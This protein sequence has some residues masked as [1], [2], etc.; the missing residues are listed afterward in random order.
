MTTYFG[1]QGFVQLLFLMLYLSGLW[2]SLLRS[3]YIK[4]NK[5]LKFQFLLGSPKKLLGN[6]VS[7]YQAREKGFWANSEAWKLMFNAL[8]L[9][10]W[11]KMAKFDDFLTKIAEFFTVFRKLAPQNFLF[12]TQRVCW[13]VFLVFPLAS[14]YLTKYC[15]SKLKISVFEL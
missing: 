12:L 2:G 9:S 3:M 6:S 13:N 7:Y 4:R 5:L 10:N 14:L 15:L 8:P 1:G 11:V